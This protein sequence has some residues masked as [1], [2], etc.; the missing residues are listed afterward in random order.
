[1]ELYP[2]FQY[3]RKWNARL[4]VKKKWWRARWNLTAATE[5]LSVK[6]WISW[7]RKSDFR[8]VH[9]MSRWMKRSAPA[10]HETLLPVFLTLRSAS[11]ILHSR[12]IGYRDIIISTIFMVIVLQ[13]H[14]VGME[15]IAYV[16]FYIYLVN[17]RRIFLGYFRSSRRNSKQT[18]QN[19]NYFITFT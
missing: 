15:S 12:Y 4:K 5:K 6:L 2:K 17:R 18:W 16:K 7:S 14:V 1:M 11:T 19:S 8:E 9:L 10:P 3:C 13:R